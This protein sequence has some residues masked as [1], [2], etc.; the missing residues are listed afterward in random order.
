MCDLI[1]AA[2]GRVDVVTAARGVGFRDRETNVRQ[3]VHVDEANI[4]SVCLQVQATRKGGRTEQAVTL[5]R[6][7]N[8]YE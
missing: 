1:I 5:V 2:G 6:V 8:D 3:R 7:L 4:K